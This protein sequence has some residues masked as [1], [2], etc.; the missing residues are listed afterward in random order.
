MSETTELNISE[1][2]GKKVVSA[3]LTVSSETAEKL[4]EV[5]E[6]YPDL[7]PVLV[8]EVLLIERD[9]EEEIDTED[10]IDKVWDISCELYMEAK[11]LEDDEE[12]SL[13]EVLLTDCQ[14][15][16]NMLLKDILN[17]TPPEFLTSIK[18]ALKHDIEILGSFEYVLRMLPDS[19]MFSWVS[20]KEK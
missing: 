13:A 19:V 12:V 16:S 1:H 8:S 11:D 18:S 20:D 15:V 3:K 9:D 7:F 14:D 6:T 17:L 10:I 5:M 2:Q 4:N